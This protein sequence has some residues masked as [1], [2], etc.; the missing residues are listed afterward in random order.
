VGIFKKVLKKAT[1]PVRKSIKAGRK[2]L[3]T[4]K[5]VAKASRRPLKTGKKVF[6]STV[7]K[8]IRGGL[9]KTRKVTRGIKR[10]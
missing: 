6:K 1:K 4:A 5:K 9:K 10:K 3:K 2:P 8:P 7:S